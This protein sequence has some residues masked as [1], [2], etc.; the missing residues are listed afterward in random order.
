MIHTLFLFLFLFIL[1]SYSNEAFETSIE[2][3]KN[4]NQI[5]SIFNKPVQNGYHELPGSDRSHQHTTE[6]DDEIKFIDDNLIDQRLPL[7][8]TLKNTPQLSKLVLT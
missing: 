6:N 4:P 8:I 2:E 1:F 3:K 7:N 5:T